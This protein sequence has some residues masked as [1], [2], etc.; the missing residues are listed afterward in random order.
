MHPAYS[1]IFFTTASGAGYGLLAWLGLLAAFG[2]APPDPLFGFIAMGLATVLFTGGLLSS[3]AHLGRPERAWRAISQWRTSWL[4][5]EG[6]A[7][8]ATYAPAVVLALGWIILRRFDGVFAC[9]GLGS[10]LTSAVTVFCT[11]MIYQSLK[12]IRQWNNDWTVANYLLLAAYTGG[13]LLVLLAL[14]FGVYRPMFG[15]TT[16]AL[17]VAAAIAKGTYWC[18]IDGEPP[19]SS[20]RTATGL[21][22]FTSV[23]LFEAPH[24]EANFIMREMG[25]VIARKHARKLRGFAAITLF[26]LPGVLLA[27]LVVATPHARLAVGASLAATISAG[28]GVA[29]ERWLF[30][31]EATHTSMLYYGKRA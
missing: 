24:T 25:F 23:R 18:S 2:V 17:L 31:A 19:R 8:V 11:A 9:A 21:T 22:A 1:V 29:V 4:S 6:V 12:P 26:G 20:L 13:I 16:L 27:A 5:R 15:A 28:I 7:A 3:T 10:A 14:T 30:F